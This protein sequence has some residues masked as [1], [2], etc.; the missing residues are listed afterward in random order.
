MQENREEENKRC[1]KPQNMS[2]DMTFC[3]VP[4]YTSFP[5]FIILYPILISLKNTKKILQ[6][7]DL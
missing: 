7:I 6:K 5:P 4:I 3:A 2:F 1:G